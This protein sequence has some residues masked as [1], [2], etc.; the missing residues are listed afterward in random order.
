MTSTEQPRRTI[1]EQ[2]HFDARV[3]S[4]RRAPSSD[5]ARA[6]CRDIALRLTLALNSSRIRT[7]GKKAQEGLFHDVGVILSGLLHK[8]LCGEAVTANRRPA[9]KMWSGNKGKGRIGF[10]AF[11]SKVDA[12]VRL[13]L[14]QV[15]DAMRFADPM[16]HSGI[17]GKA[18]G[19]IPSPMLIEVAVSQ[20]CTSE[21]RSNDWRLEQ[22][23][24]AE[25]LKGD[26]LVVFNDF[27]SMRNGKVINKHVKKRLPSAPQSGELLSFMKRLNEKVADAKFTGCLPPVLQMQF[28][29]SPYIGGRI[30]AL[31]GE[32]NFQNLPEEERERITI[33]GEAV[34]EVDITA[35]CLSVFLGMTRGLAP[36]STDPYQAGRLAEFDR[37][38]VKHWFTSSLQGGK[39]KSR[40]PA[41][42]S[43]EKR[44]GSCRQI[45]AAAMATYPSLERLS[46]LLPPEIAAT[47]PSDEHRPWATGQYLA[48]VEARVIRETIGLIMDQGG[49]ALPMHDALIVPRSW[50][51]RAEAALGEVSAR[52]QLAGLQWSVSGHGRA[53]DAPGSETTKAAEALELA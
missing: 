43:Q 15:Q 46:H 33:D 4:L 53:G 52:M 10:K 18:T 8:G 25:A 27:P 29:P 2:T 12:L 20:G 11:W 24:A 37:A 36:V 3:I 39:L 42:T 30:Y 51:G 5:N 38:T 22:S 49:V 9:A 13:G 21:T 32:D 45:A 28:G 48:A 17:G 23:G 14:V 26:D 7:L 35:S 50:S 34:A 40:W 19:L 1:S 47:L 16:Q 31:G 41:G 44:K 6:L